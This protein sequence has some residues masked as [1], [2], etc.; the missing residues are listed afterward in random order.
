MNH[1]DKT[2]EI[3]SHLD[4]YGVFNKDY[5]KDKTPSKKKDIKSSNRRKPR[6]TLDLHGLKSAE[7]TI[8]LRSALYRCREKG[9]KELLIIHGKGYHS[10]NAER[11]VLK[12]L[13]FQML[14]HELDPFIRD[15]K[16][17]LPKDGGEGATLVYL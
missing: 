13:V 10:I 12:S 2:D 15:Y 1:Q 16:T 7:A 9:I 5:R 8:Q 6:E 4:K 11:P 3:L 17:A 14:E